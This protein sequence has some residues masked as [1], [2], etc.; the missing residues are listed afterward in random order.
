MIVLVLL[1]VYL[2]AAQP[3]A[4]PLEA[5]AANATESSAAEDF[6]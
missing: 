3:G 4:A 6:T 5:Q 2:L 1:V